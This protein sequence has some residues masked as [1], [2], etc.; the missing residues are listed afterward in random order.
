M[1]ELAH[2]LPVPHQ[3]L[4]L[5]LQPA[6]LLVQ[7][8][9]LAHHVLAALAAVLVTLP[10]LPA[11]RRLV[12]PLP[13]A[14]ALISP[15]PRSLPLFKAVRPHLAYLLPALQVPEEVALAAVQDALPLQQ[16]QRLRHRP[17]TSS[18]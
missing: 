15:I 16:R 7:A 10:S 6:H 2:L 4:P 3:V 13:R 17:L 11:L 8:P 12:S 5:A 1:V 14:H 9:H 18:N